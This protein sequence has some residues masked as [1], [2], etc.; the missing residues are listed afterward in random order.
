MLSLREVDFIVE[1]QVGLK[2]PDD[3]LRC[4]INEIEDREVEVRL[5]LS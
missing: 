3:Y 2:H 5:K 4:F 1:V